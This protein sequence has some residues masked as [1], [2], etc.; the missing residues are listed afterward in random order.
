MKS[1]QRKLP[2]KIK[3]QLKRQIYLRSQGK[4]MV[5]RT[6]RLLKNGNIEFF[7]KPRIYIVNSPEGDINLIQSENKDRL[8]K[9]V[10]QND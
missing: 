8:L 4:A 7:R 9:E 3:K 10:K 2:R 5:V 6:Y 1:N